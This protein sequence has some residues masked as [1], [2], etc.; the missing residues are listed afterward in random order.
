[1]ISTLE[2]KKLNPEWTELLLI[3]LKLGLSPNEIREFF[4][5]NQRPE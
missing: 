4:L 1:M 3:A 5:S 2:S